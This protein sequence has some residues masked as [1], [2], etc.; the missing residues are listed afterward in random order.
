VRLVRALVRGT[1]TCVGPRETVRGGPGA[2]P[3]PTGA[4]SREGTTSLASH[5]RRGAFLPPLPVPA[6]QAVQGLLHRS[7][8]FVDRQLRAGRRAGVAGASAQQQRQGARC[9]D[10][11]AVRAASVPRADRRGGSRSL[12]QPQT[13]DRHEF[14]RRA[15]CRRACDCRVDRSC[16]G[17]ACRGVRALPRSHH[18]VRAAGGPGHPLRALWAYR[19]DRRGRSERV[20]PTAVAVGRR[21]AR[22][23]V[24]QHNGSGILLRRKCGFLC[25]RGRRAGMAPPADTVPA[26]AIGVGQGTAE[27]RPAVRP[28]HAG[29]P[30]HSPAAVRHW[31][32]RIQFWNDGAGDR[33]VRVSLRCQRSGVRPVGHRCRCRRRRDSRRRGDRTHGEEDVARRCG[34]R[35]P[36]DR[37]DL[38]SDARRLVALRD[39]RRVRI[40]IVHDARADRPAAGIGSGHA[41]PG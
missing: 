37:V 25:R 32:M 27:R 17:V 5:E 4:G 29:H 30:T 8:G 21:R 12:R 6:E 33:E 39:L 31:S 38:H 3:N 18:A 10:C 16:D 41:R 14:A 26:E 13:S 9:G 24:D 28:E 23:S 20:A 34:I 35:R 2:S 36:H 7:D 40:D 11:S 22:R 19:R 1:G 15:E